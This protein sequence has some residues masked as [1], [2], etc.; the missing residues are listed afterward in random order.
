MD[1]ERDDVMKRSEAVAPQTKGTITSV[2]KRPPER[3]RREDQQGLRKNEAEKRNRTVREAVRREGEGKRHDSL[4][5][6]V[7][8]P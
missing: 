4:L 2:F 6:K 1:R 3:E 8:C 5:A 7:R